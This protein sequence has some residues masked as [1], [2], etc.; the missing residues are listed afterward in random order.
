M[1]GIS[2]K[3][4][5]SNS[6]HHESIQDFKRYL[7]KLGVAYNTIDK[8]VSYH[9]GYAKDKEGNIDFTKKLSATIIIT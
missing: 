2:L 5:K 4:G 7:E 9:Y 1:K 3:C 8:Y 6:M